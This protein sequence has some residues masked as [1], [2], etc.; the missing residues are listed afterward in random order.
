MKSPWFTVPRDGDAAARATAMA[1]AM[2]W[3]VRTTS[4]L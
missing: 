1:V 4:L 2:V 3:L